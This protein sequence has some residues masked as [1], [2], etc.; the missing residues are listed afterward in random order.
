MN[1]Y[2]GN[3]KATESKVIYNNAFNTWA[4][5]TKILEGQSYI[6][7]YLSSLAGNLTRLSYFKFLSSQYLNVK[8]LG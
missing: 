6:S 2:L 8:N 1:Q 4:M 3:Q 7:S 5:K